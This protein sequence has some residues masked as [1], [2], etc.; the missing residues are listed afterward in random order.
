MIKKVTIKQTFR[1]GNKLEVNFDI[2]DVRSLQRGINVELEH[3][4]KCGLTNVTNSNLEITA[5][6]ALA[7]L[8]E[9][10]D[11]YDELKIM[12]DKLKQKHKGKRKINIFVM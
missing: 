3:G 6:I 5:K 8:M 12:E 2:L 9:Y 10:I 1:V 11:Y 7:H 4:R